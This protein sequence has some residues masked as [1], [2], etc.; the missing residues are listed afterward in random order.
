MIPR[1]GTWA[2]ALA[3]AIVLA[4]PGAAQIPER[5]S[6]TVSGEILYRGASPHGSILQVFLFDLTDQAYPEI[7][8][9]LAINNPA[10]SP[11]PFRIQFDPRRIDGRRT[12]GIQA[13]IIYGNPPH[14]TYTSR[15]S[16]YVLTRGYPS[17]VRVQLEPVGYGVQPE[18]EP[19]F[20]GRNR[21]TGTV[22]FL[23]GRVPPGSILQ[24]FLFDL[25]D[26]HYPSIVVDQAINHPQISPVP[27]ELLFDP[28]RIH[29]SRIYGVQARIIHGSPPVVVLIS[30]PRTVYVL[31][32]GH[33]NRANLVLRRPSPR[34]WD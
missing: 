21:V 10:G 19:I 2:A 1:C 15:R 33:S 13:R 7:V 27:F 28:S 9:D 34:D 3:A 24:V 11:V 32:W 17:A 6:N 31:T 16:Y 8:A 29:P 23:P 5:Y 30:T 12:Y 14:V 20:I 22:S 4:S 26:P 25:T 18:P